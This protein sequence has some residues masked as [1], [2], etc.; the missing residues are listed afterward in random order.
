MRLQRQRSIRRGEPAATRADGRA[1]GR[2]PLPTRARTCETRTNNVRDHA[3]TPPAIGGQRTRAHTRTF[4]PPTLT[5]KP[6]AS[7]T[8]TA[9]SDAAGAADAPTAKPK[10]QN[11]ARAQAIRMRGHFSSWVN[12][13]DGRPS[14]GQQQQAAWRRRTVGV[15]S[16]THSHSRRLARCHAGAL[17]AAT[18]AMTTT[19][20]AMRSRRSSWA[21]CVGLR[22]HAVCLLAGA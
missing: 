1:A 9:N 18:S 6:P 14:E 12:T 3:T 4:V 8:A 7:S 16:F 20:E 21:T 11:A 10:R 19:A 17:A 2:R 15:L 22:A 5:T 13:L